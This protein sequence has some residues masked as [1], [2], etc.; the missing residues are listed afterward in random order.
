MAAASLNTPMSAVPM[1]PTAAKMTSAIKATISAYS[2]A[3][4][5]PSETVL[6]TMTTDLSSA[7]ATR[8]WPQLMQRT[9]GNTR[10]GGLF[11]A[12]RKSLLKSVCYFLEN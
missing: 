4:A 12:A 7:P 6:R 9:P 5:P 1:A 8:E 3:V 10:T 11:A 2:T